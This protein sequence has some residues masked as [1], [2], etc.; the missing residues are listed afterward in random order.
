M[1]AG[2]SS[3]S[4]PLR[5]P[6]GLYNLKARRII[7][8][9]GLA[10]ILERDPSNRPLLKITEPGGRYLEIGYY[11]FEDPVPP[12]LRWRVPHHQYDRDFLG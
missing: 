12:A 9:H 11:T 4:I 10:T 3:R 8:P 5:P 1:A 2:W 7:D 6:A